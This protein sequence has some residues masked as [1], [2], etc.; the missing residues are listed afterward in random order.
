MD[1]LIKNKNH[2]KFKLPPIFA[3]IISYGVMFI[4]LSIISPYFLTLKNLLNVGQFSSMMG[5]AATG[6]TLVLVSGGID[7]STGAVMGL[8]CMFIAKIIPETGGVALAILSGIGLG[9]ACGAFNGIVITRAKIHPIITT[10]AT[11]SIFRGFAFIWNKGMSVPITNVKFGEL[12]RG[13]LGVVPVPLI[14]MIAVFIIF[15][16]V[17]KYTS[18]GRKVY[19]VGGNSIASYLSG[20]NVKST[21]LIVYIICGATAG[22]AGTMLASMIGAGVSNGGSGYELNVI[23]A[24]ILGGTSLSGGKGNI[25]GTAFGVLILVTLSN[26]MNLMGVQAFWQMVARGAVLMLAV[27]MDVIRGGGYE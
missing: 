19:S 4:I 17:M 13:Y 20:I 23:A 16:I 5:I 8:T 2:R 18:F 7:I 27:I 1:N 22:L 3:I 6:V 25:I 10:L 21:R 11:M 14:V 26:G 15:G 24:A 12:G 9:A